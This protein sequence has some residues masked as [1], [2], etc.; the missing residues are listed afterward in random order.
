MRRVTTPRRSTAEVVHISQPEQS[1]RS[2][3]GAGSGA[4]LGEP[5]LVADL[6]C[7]A[8]MDQAVEQGRGHLGVAED[9]R[10]LTEG[11]GL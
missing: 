2:A 9:G 3:I 5:A 1:G 4:V 8:E 7:I 6:D 10:L 11:E